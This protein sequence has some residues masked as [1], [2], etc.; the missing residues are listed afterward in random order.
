MS[1]ANRKRVQFGTTVNKDLLEEFKQISEWTEIPISKLTDKAFAYV[2][3]NYGRPGF[4]D[5]KVIKD[6]N[7]TSII[8]A[9]THHTTNENLAEEDFPISDEELNDMADAIALLRAKKNEFLSIIQEYKPQNPIIDE[10]LDQPIELTKEEKREILLKRKQ[11]TFGQ[12]SVYDDIDLNNKENS[13]LDP[14][15]IFDLVDE[16]E[17]KNKKG[18]QEQGSIYDDIEFLDSGIIDADYEFKKSKK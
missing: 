1:S 2:I 11:K 12:G 4:P 17:R 13:S 7:I 18:K 6:N 10:D 9:K 5:Y 8:E 16:N 15:E 3:D 14:E